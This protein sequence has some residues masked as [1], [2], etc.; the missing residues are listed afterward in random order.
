MH[1]MQWQDIDFDKEGEQDQ[2]IAPEATNLATTFFSHIS[3]CLH[4]HTTF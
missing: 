3:N 2:Y 1:H 4:I